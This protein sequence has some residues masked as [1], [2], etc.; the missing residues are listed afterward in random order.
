[1]ANPEHKNDANIEA[2]AHKLEQNPQIAKLVQNVNDQKSRLAGADDIEKSDKR[3]K[4]EQ[5]LAP[6]NPRS[7]EQ[8]E[9]VNP[10]EE[11][12]DPVAYLDRIFG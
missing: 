4:D 6:G 12:E 5:E 1:M 9:Q 7:L 2:L 3:Q 8:M 10:R 11:G